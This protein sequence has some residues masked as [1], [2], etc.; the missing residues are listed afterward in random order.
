MAPIGKSLCPKT[1][2]RLPACPA[3]A[4]T[5]YCHHSTAGK[6]TVRKST[7]TRRTHSKLASLRLWDY[8][9]CGF[10]RHPWHLSSSDHSETPPPLRSHPMAH[11]S[12]GLQAPESTIGPHGWA[13]IPYTRYYSFTP[14]SVSPYGDRI[15]MWICAPDRPPLSMGFGISVASWL[16]LSPGR[17]LLLV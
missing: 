7:R 13:S 17:F 16:L 15:A 10:L 2:L 5:P 1:H 11:S 14:A 9:G 4:G 8:S 12:Y 3:N 6:I